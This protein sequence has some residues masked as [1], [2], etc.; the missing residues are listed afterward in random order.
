MQ[1]LLFVEKAKIF[2]DIKNFTTN[3][4]LNHKNSI[5]MRESLMLNIA[6]L[7]QAKAKGDWV[8]K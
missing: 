1:N 7:E 4:V 2:C 6:M 8:L 3:I 5:E